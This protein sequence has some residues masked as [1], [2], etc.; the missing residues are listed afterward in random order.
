MSSKSA[1]PLFDISEEEHRQK[2]LLINDQRQWA[3]PTS[4]TYGI[5]LKRCDINTAIARGVLWKI[6]HL[7][8]LKALSHY[9]VSC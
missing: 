7:L 5:R 8:T 2:I 4:A 9:C 3:S 6:L 1:M